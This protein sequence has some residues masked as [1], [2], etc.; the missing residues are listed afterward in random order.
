MTWQN[1]YGGQTFTQFI[2]TSSK[3]GDVNPYWVIGRLADMNAAV[4]EGEER[5]NKAEQAKYKNKTHH[6]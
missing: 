4:S 6:R 1:R 3:A 2:G 5:R